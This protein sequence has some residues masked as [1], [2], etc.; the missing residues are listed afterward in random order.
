MEINYDQ[1]EKII[2]K[3]KQEMDTLQPG[4]EEHKRA[5]EEYTSY[6]N[7]K[8]EIDQ[9][10]R[11]EEQQALEREFKKTMNDKD[12]NSKMKETWIK[13]GGIGLLFVISVL[14]ENFGGMRSKIGEITRIVKIWT[15]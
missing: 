13:V 14:I 2:A 6:W 3:C 11:D 9:R 1:L 10:F 5:S 7:L 4:S 15:I 12:H 8:L